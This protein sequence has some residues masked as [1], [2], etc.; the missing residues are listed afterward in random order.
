MKTTTLLRAFGLFAML[1]AFALTYNSIHSQTISG[2]AYREYK[3]NGAVDPALN[4][5]LHNGVT[6]TR[7]AEQGLQGVNIKIFGPNG[8]QL[9]GSPV[10]SGPNGNWTFTIPGSYSDPE[11]I[12]EFTPPSGYSDGM[13]G[14]ANQGN[15]RRISLGGTTT[16]INWTA[17]LPSDH[18]QDN[19]KVGVPKVF[20]GAGEPNPISTFSTYDYNTSSLFTDSQDGS[21]NLN[22]NALFQGIQPQT[23]LA[24]QMTTGTLYGAAFDKY[25][26]KWYVGAYHRRNG[27]LGPTTLFPTGPNSAIY[28]LD[29]NTNN[30]SLWLDLAVIFNNPNICGPW[31]YNQITGTYTPPNNQIAQNSIG[32][33]DLSFD[34][35]TLYAVNLF[36]NQV[37][38]IPIDPNGNPPS[39][40]TA[41]KVY[42]LPNPC[43]TAPASNGISHAAACGLGLNRKTGR[44]FA[45][46]T[47]KGPTNSDLIGKVYSFDPKGSTAQTMTDELTI[48][49]NIARPGVDSIYPAE[50][51]GKSGDD[52]ITWEPWL[53]NI[54][55]VEEPGTPERIIVFAKNRK[56]DVL[57]LS[58]FVSA[59]VIFT[60]CKN[61]SGQWQLTDNSYGCP[62]TGTYSAATLSGQNMETLMKNNKAGYYNYHGA[63]GVAASGAGFAI[64]GFTELA[65]AGMDNISTNMRMGAFYMKHNNGERHRDIFL[66]QNSN[67]NFRVAKANTFGDIEAACAAAPIE[68]GNSVWNDAN[69]NGIQDPGE[70]GI[71]GVTVNLYRDEN[72][73]GT[74]NSGIDILIATAITNN[75][76]K[77]YFRRNESGTTGIV[78]NGPGFVSGQNLDYFNNYLLAVDNG[79]DFNSTPVVGQLNNMSLTIANNS[80]GGDADGLTDGPRP[81]T[82]GTF[83]NSRYSIGMS[84]DGNRDSDGINPGVTPGKNLIAFSTGEAG[85]ILNGID[86]G[87]KPGSIPLCT[88]TFESIS[89]G[90]CNP[91]SNKYSVT[92]SVVFNNQPTSDS[93]VIVNGNQRIFFLAPFTSP[94][95]FTFNDIESTGGSIQML[96]YFGANN[97]CLDDFTY[98]APSRCIPCNISGVTSNATSCDPLT[99]LY[100]VRGLISFTDAPTTGTMT[101]TLDGVNPIIFNAPFISPISYEYLGLSADG[102][103]HN[104]VVAFSDAQTC[105]YMGSYRAPESCEPCRI[106]EVTYLVS[107]CDEVNYTYTVSGSINFTDAPASGTLKLKVDGVVKQTFN[108]PFTS[109]TIFSVTGLPSDGNG[110][111]ISVEF[112]D[113]DCTYFGSFVA[114]APCSPR[115]GSVGDF[116]WNDLNGNGIQDFGEPGLKNIRVIL[117]NITTGD[118]LGD[119]LTNDN[120]KYLFTDLPSGQYYIK[121]ITPVDFLITTPNIGSDDTDSDLDNSRGPGTSPIFTLSPGENNTGM[122][123]GYIKCACITGRV[124]FD[125]NSNGIFDTN[126]NG[127]N[128]VEVKLYDANTR[129]YITKTF[130]MTE[131]GTGSRDGYYKFKC[132]RPGFYY[133]EFIRPGNMAASLAFQGFDREKDSDISHTYGFNTTSSIN[134][135]PGQVVTGIG[136]GF[137]PEAIFGNLVWLDVN[138]NGIQDNGE[139][140]MKDIGVKAYTSDNVLINY[141]KTEDNGIY[142][143]DGI[144]KG[145]YYIKFESSSYYGFTTPNSGNGVNDSKVNNI[146]GYGT[147]RTY[148]INNREEL[149]FIDAG[150][151]NQALPL[152]WLGIEVQNVKSFNLLEWETGSEIN[153]SHFV[154]ERR[155]ESEK[156]FTIVGRVEASRSATNSH[157]YSY[158]DYN[159]GK[160]GRYYY[161]VKQID[162]DGWFTY[163]KM[164]SILL[165]K[166]SSQ[167]TMNIYPN[168]VDK[169]LTIDYH[170]N[171]NDDVEF[172][173]YDELGKYVNSNL[174]SGS[175]KSG[176]H[177]EYLN[178]QNLLPG[179]YY[180]QIK[181]TQGLVNKKFSISRD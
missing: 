107:A 24:S 104:F 180:I 168:P 109:P 44:V 126:E 56:G 26:N 73:S 131:P 177:T 149:S 101:I 163:S 42:N 145:D 158:E 25:R 54:D 88:V 134:L 142:F 92:G 111:N 147:T 14:S 83:A 119:T 19:P 46:V 8:V 91:L 1:F 53:S 113:E 71:D 112:S 162:H 172:T 62:S 11:V 97:D 30:P 77:Y 50:F 37:Y 49:L 69:S 58:P 17:Q 47:C 87:F 15:V 155:L 137:Q 123:V 33:V 95:N 6:N 100:N 3:I 148:R 81:I 63:E 161:R 84:G 120:G 90:Q 135:I 20:R 129:Q 5:T 118:I 105:T 122:D 60:G 139:P 74:Y 35:M 28:K 2:T 45:T 152:E 40:A 21:K 38:A 31:S 98:T 68:V 174:I 166:E 36:T 106:T 79:S 140:G 10:V 70:T 52:D 130:T 102:N 127:I 151:V 179:S 169:E 23:D 132:L 34:G 125:D 124:F 99:Q 86:F 43:S 61:S 156:D 159:I 178:T 165:T 173:L 39:S 82:T 141:V 48:N 153:N 110:H 32:D 117:I 171:T 80:A 55:F 66:M 115:T 128:G 27:G 175:R 133:I 13:L 181:T 108:A 167:L 89:I 143:L 65:S 157:Q 114:P 121:V 64:P 170:L 160:A 93:L 18:C 7:H 67:L 146:N 22:N 76:G 78:S 96:T 29:A 41:I 4:V 154:I 72:G 12:V 75:D 85:Q 138:S 51:W 94:V 103:Q 116:V 9:S 150:L 176:A 144:S 59:G 136:A 164:V 16:G 57:D